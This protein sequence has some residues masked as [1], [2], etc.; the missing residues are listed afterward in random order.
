MKRKK[1]KASFQ[2]TNWVNYEPLREMKCSYV[3]AIGERGTG[4]TYGIKKICLQKFAQN[5]EQF[6]YIRR[7]HSYITQRRMIR[8]F[9]DIAEECFDIIG[10]SVTYNVNKGF[11]T[12]IDGK[13][14]IIGYATSLE[15]VM[16]EK[17]VSFEK[18]TTVLFDE[19]VDL[20]Y[21]DNEIER[22]LNIISTVTRSRENIEIFMCGNTISKNCP[23]FDMFG[24][25][26]N[27]I[28]RG[29]TYKIDHKMGVSLALYY[30]KTKV[31]A[32][33]ETNKKHKYLGFDDNES[34]KMILYGEW[35][36]KSFE[37]KSI[38]GFGWNSERVL[39]PCYITAMHQS[40]EMSLLDYNKSKV[41]ILFV[42]KPNTQNGFVSAKIKYNVCS[43][44]TTPLTN[45]NGN[46]PMM[47]SFS[48]FID[49][50]TKKLI[51]IA[52]DC[53]GCGRVIFT[54]NNTGTEFMQIV[55]VI[56]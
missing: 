12:Y 1:N 48:T 25:D 18:V 36:T 15:D 49:E 33:G 29:E 46:V 26:T 52:M 14:E 27:R 5:R 2:T 47:N 9:D 8:L 35:E 21:F 56:K 6:L 42:R 34:V 40:Y 41:P 17:G 16:Q 24:I 55:K 38:D 20:N 31:S 53:I 4:K 11:I 30:T 44:M 23:Y 54:D 32:I 51:Q 28:K 3:M 10:D 37:T 50:G 22:F 43:D 45:K 13:E 7:C 39:I 19:F